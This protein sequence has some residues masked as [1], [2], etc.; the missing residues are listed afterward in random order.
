MGTPEFA[1]TILKGMLKAGVNIC[2]VVTSPDKPAGRGQK[3]SESAV[4]KYAFQNNLNLFQPTNL[5]DEKFITALRDLNADLFVVVAFRML[6]E[7]IFTMPPKGTINLH[8][9]LLPQYRGAAP[10]NWAIINGEKSTGITTFFIEKEIDTGKIIKSKAVSISENM[11]AGEL[12]DNLADEGV[13]LVNVTIE[14]IESNTVQLF[15]QKD[16]IKRELKN[17]PKI[18]KSDCEINWSWTVERVHNFIRGLSP[19]PGAWFNMTFKE[20]K[21]TCKVYDSIILN[22]NVDFK[23][24]LKLK[25]EFFLFRC[26]DG[27]IAIKEIQIEGKR[28]MNLKE[29][30][31]D[32]KM[33]DIDL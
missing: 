5:K 16:L 4:K 11:T 7:I 2:G 22:S 18:F 12:H 29:F 8:A 32:N 19:Y 20:K 21:L 9:S 15:D 23:D 24:P 33:E 1:V 14:D 10:I 13:N 3:I 28:K 17:A 27:E 25:N 30:I 6:P 26:S 31:S